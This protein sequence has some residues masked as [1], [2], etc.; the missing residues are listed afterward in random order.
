MDLICLA[1]TGRSAA[2]RLP[3][4]MAM[5]ATGTPRFLTDANGAITEAAQVVYEDSPELL[6]FVKVFMG[7]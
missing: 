3:P 5:M 4:I 7:K 6:E 1:K 2:P